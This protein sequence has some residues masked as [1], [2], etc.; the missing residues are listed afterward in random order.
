M[1]D[2]NFVRCQAYVHFTIIAFEPRLGQRKRWTFRTPYQPV[3]LHRVLI[4]LCNQPLLL[5]NGRSGQGGVN[6]GVQ[7]RPLG[8]AVV[9]Y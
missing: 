8:S 1:E 7:L 9:P 5:L 6:N 3:P 4:R 2:M